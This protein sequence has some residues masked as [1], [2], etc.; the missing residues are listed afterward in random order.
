MAQLQNGS[1]EMSESASTSSLG[2]NGS[3]NKAPGSQLHQNSNNH[4]K[5]MSNMIY[6][7]SSLLQSVS[8]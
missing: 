5:Q 2:S 6:N 8:K 1:G 7:P 4:Q 3:H